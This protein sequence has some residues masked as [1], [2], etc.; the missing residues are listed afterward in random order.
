MAICDYLMTFYVILLYK[1]MLHALGL[2]PST[3]RRH[4][5]AKI[6]IPEQASAKA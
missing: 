4:L 3:L 1:E 6:F 2:F 5:I